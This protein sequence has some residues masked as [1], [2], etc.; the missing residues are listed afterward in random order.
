MMEKNLS[1]EMLT[2]SQFSRLTGVGRKLLIYYDNSGLFSPAMKTE[3]GYRYYSYRQI[4][5][6]FVIL[7]L[8]ELG[9]SLK[10]IH[11]YMEQYSPQD[12]IEFLKKQER[13][14][15]LKIRQFQSTRDMLRSRLKRAEEA[16]EGTC[17]GVTL[18][19]EKETLLF[20]SDPLNHMLK[21]EIS[22]EIWDR[23]E[24]KC[25]EAG[26]SNGYADGYI[27]DRTSLLAGETERADYVVF[28]VES[29]EFANGV[30]PEGYY[31][32]AFVRGDFEENCTKPA[33]QRIRKYIREHGLEIA[34]CAYEER[35]LDEVSVKDPDS[36]LLRIRVQVK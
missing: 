1:Q 25:R 6:L 13:D 26:I 32:T 23:F 29:P 5:S 16:V 7:V 35:L 17:R 31:V 30:I 22:F 36:Q 20:Q 27:V 12:E 33:Y 4:H 2:I 19:Y 21:K 34:G 18:T 28:Y 3:N 8:K 24:E 14:I 11:R 10:E 9:L 15:S